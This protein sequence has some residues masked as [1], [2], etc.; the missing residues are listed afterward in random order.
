M[1]WDFLD[2]RQNSICCRNWRRKGKEQSFYTT[3]V[4]LLGSRTDQQKHGKCLIAVLQLFYNPKDFLGAIE[5][6]RKDTG[7]FSDL[8]V[9]LC[10]DLSWT[11][12]EP[13][14]PSILHHLVHPLYILYIA[15]TFKFLEVQKEKY[16][17][18]YKGKHSIKKIFFNA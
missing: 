9:E 10:Q 6:L 14:G 13:S 11:P 17:C 16:F 8:C 1:S 12:S 4:H 3:Q 7:A 15:R 18:K 5:G 2:H